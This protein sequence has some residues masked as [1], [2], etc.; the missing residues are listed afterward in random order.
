MNPKPLVALNH[1]TVPTAMSSF[2][3]LP[4]T[5]E[6]LRATRKGDRQRNPGGVDHGGLGATV[7]PRR[8]G[9]TRGVPAKV[10]ETVDRPVPPPERGHRLSLPRAR[11]FTEPFTVISTASVPPATVTVALALART[12]GWNTRVSWQLA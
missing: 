5:I 2:P 12:V 4:R 3:L 8:A 1:L 7:P 9:S 6:N 11:Y 10:D